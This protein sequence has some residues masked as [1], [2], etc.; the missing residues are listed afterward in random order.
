MSKITTNKQGT[1]VLLGILALAAIGTFA[2]HAFA[3]QDEHAQVVQ[4]LGMTT[5]NDPSGPLQSMGWTAGMAVAAVMAGI[6][7]FT[8]VRSHA[9]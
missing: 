1:G 9:R 3:Q 4:Q 2:Q 7:V 8:A 5:S 6:G